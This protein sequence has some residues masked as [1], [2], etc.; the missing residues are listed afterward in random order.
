MAFNIFR[1]LLGDSETEKKKRFLDD[2][3]DS[4]G[5]GE[6]ALAVYLQ[7]MAF[8]ACVRR[9]GAAV[10]AV[11][12]NTYKDKKRTKAKEHWR[13]NYDPNPNQ[14]RTEFMMKLVAELYTR[15]EAIVVETPEQYRYVADGFSVEKSLSG[16]VYKNVSC[17][18]LAIAGEFQ[19]KDV[20]RITLAGGK[21]S[22]MLGGLAEAEGR[23]MSSAT[24][25]YIRDNGRRGVLKVGETAEGQKDF[26]E[27]YAALVNE[28]FRTFFTAEN[29]VLPL[30]DGYEYEDKSAAAAGTTRDVRAMM[31]D[32]MELTAQA[33]GMPASV[34]FGKN[35]TKEDFRSFMEGN[36]VPIVS[37]LAQEINRKNYGRYN[38]YG[39]SHIVPDYAGVR[40]A[41]LFEIADPID[42]LIG[43]GGF[44]VNDIR[45]RLGMSVIDEP[46]AWQHWMTKNYSP[47]G[48]LVDGVADGKP[49]GDPKK[50][51][52]ERA[53][54]GEE[55]E[56]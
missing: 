35:V 17:E 29:A 37:A 27:T 2:K 44:C 52:P 10:A 18:G 25:K 24:R 53:E 41:D 40:F 12:W 23:M 16:N 42:K 7:Q 30:F 3:I 13:W 22:G 51:D 9:I 11:E 19:A 6:D 8:W 47:A 55:H 43:S 34:A 1:W 46:W 54:E 36:V 4:Q 14:T 38:V 49:K 39:G 28:K 33:I 48:D 5:C 45:M 56:E 31:D 32:I 21:I 15:Q 50:E 26:D 20:L